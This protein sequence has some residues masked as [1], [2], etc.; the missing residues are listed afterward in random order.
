MEITM[1]IGII[2]FSLKLFTRKTKN[3]K[4]ANQVEYLAQKRAQMR[5]IQD[6]EKKGNR[7]KKKKPKMKQLKVN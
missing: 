3:Q 2:V 5:E 7:R 1:I 4:M 6:P